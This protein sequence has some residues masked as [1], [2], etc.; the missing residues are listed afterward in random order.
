L[1]ISLAEGVGK[2]SGVNEKTQF[3]RI[4]VL[5]SIAYIIA[6]NA[7]VFFLS[8][9]IRLHQ[10]LYMALIVL[11]CCQ[12]YI[13]SIWAK[14]VIGFILLICGIYGIYQLLPLSDFSLNSLP[15]LL[16][17]LTI[18]SLVSGIGLIS[19]KSV[20]AF[21]DEQFTN[22]SIVIIRVLKAL[23]ILLL[24]GFLALLSMDIKRM[25]IS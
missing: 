16:I 8:T 2:V 1:T 6:I 3:G 23:W 22:R 4:I 7:V 11:I 10:Y 20:L 18:V 12:L 13:G 19:S 25:F 9:S 5:A 24:V 17:F 15:I 21:L 14:W